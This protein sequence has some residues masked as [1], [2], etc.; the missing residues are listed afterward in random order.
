MT[1][2]HRMNTSFNRKITEKS[3]PLIIQAEKQTE[4][5][6]LEISIEGRDVHNA[7]PDSTLVS[8]IFQ[9]KI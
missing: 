3:K 1:N 6:T 2:T 9:E 5:T 4:N 8:R 7:V